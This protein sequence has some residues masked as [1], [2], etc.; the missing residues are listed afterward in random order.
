MKRI[1]YRVI[2]SPA[3]LVAFCEGIHVSQT[4][5]LHGLPTEFKDLSGWLETYIHSISAGRLLARVAF[6]QGPVEGVCQGVLAQV[7]EE[8]L[9]D[10]EGR[11]VGC[12]FLASA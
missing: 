9:V 10:L 4:F 2:I 7:A 3:F 6:C 12:K 8:S 5:L 1:W 11:E